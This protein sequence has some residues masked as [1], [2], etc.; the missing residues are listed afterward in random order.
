[1]M[2]GLP[3]STSFGCGYATTSNTV[4]KVFN[5]IENQ[6]KLSR[7]AKLF[8]FWKTVSHKVVYAKSTTYTEEESRGGWVR[9]NFL[10]HMGRVMGD[11]ILPFHSASLHASYT[12]RVSHPMVCMC[13]V[14]K[15]VYF[16]THNLSANQLLQVLFTPSSYNLTQQGSPD[17]AGPAE[18]GAALQNGAFLQD[19]TQYFT[20]AVNYPKSQISK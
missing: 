10:S 8:G 16:T 19:S 2:D 17:C 11:L 12:L 18:K 1:M 9:M 5:I 15:G 13:P 20:S 14:F 3:D 4:N 6:I 7:L